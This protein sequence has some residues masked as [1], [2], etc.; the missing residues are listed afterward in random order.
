V[1]DARAAKSESYDSP[2]IRGRGNVGSDGR[3]LCRVSGS[4]RRDDVVVI[5]A[6]GTVKMTDLLLGRF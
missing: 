4:E 3:R 1:V 5:V 2:H 6:V